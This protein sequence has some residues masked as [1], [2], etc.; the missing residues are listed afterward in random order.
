MPELRKVGL[1][2]FYSTPTAS[3]IAAVKVL[4][5]PGEA[6]VAQA[7]EQYRLAGE[8][9]AARLGVPPPRGSS[10][11]F[12]DVA[13][14]LDA[15]GLGGFLEDCVERGLFVA[16]GPSFGPYP[17]HVRLCFSAAPPDVVDRGVGVLAALLGAPPLPAVAAAAGRG[18]ES[19]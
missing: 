18:I 10:F 7:R 1:H 2:S 8:R 6:W 15:R 13:G 11:L 12:L 4:A 16:P 5:G 3:Q 17:T 19:S 14:R 9:A